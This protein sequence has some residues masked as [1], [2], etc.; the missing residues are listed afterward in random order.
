MGI[1]RP[2]N[3]NAIKKMN[4]KERYQIYQSVQSLNWRSATRDIN[5]IRSDWLQCK[6]YVQM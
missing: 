3:I 6:L 2:V 1:K 5:Q 4:K